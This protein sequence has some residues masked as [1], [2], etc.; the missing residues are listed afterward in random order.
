MKW[1]EELPPEKSWSSLWS[2]YI[3]CG[4]CPGIRRVEGN[5]P[6]CGSPPYKNNDVAAVDVGKFIVENQTGAR[7]V[8]I[9]V[10]RQPVRLS[11]ETATGAEL[12]AVAIAR[13]L[14]I[15]PDFF[16]LVEGSDGTDR[17][18]GDHDVLQLS[19]HMRFIAAAPVAMGAEGRYEDYVY[20]Q[21]LE[22]EWKRPVTH[23]DTCAGLDATRQPSPRAAIVV[24][25]WSYFETRVER[26]LRA[27][28]RNVPARLADDT[29]QRYSSI[30]SRLDRLYRVLFQTTYW[31]DL[32]ELGFDDIRHHLLLVQ[33]RRNA[34]A[35]GDPSAIDDSL[36]ASV[37]ENLRQ[38]HE[39]WI[40]AYNR[41]GT[42]P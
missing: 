21:L 11:G 37:V 2:G 15:Q 16:L 34:F 42:G 40:A 9:S 1:Y 5:C 29:L 23:Q 32:T 31:A 3:L 35:H 12:K 6:A 27:G 22:R 24:L 4:D 36:V 41:R 38:E 20:L 33:E 13:G 7:P 26:L 30:G 8:T 25:F 19:E 10:N 18:V 39:G 17:L 28:M 14:R